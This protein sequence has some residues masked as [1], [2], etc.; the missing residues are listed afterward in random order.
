MNPTIDVN[1]SI[2][3]HVDILD[4]VKLEDYRTGGRQSYPLITDGAW[5]EGNGLNGFAQGVDVRADY[6]YRINEVWVN[7]TSDVDDEIRPYITL[8]NGTLTFDNSQQLELTAPFTIPVTLKFQNC[9]MEKPQQVTV[10]VTF[11][12]IK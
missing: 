7:D 8:N 3:Y 9:W 1:N 5:V 10:N 11:N 6:M 2:P 4:Y 12:P